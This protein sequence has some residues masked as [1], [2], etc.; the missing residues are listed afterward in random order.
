M[1]F[2][3]IE[4]QNNIEENY[5]L[6]LKQIK[7]LCIGNENNIAILSNASALLKIFL[8]DVNWVGFYLLDDISQD[9]LLGPFQGLPACFKIKKGQGVCGFAVKINSLVNVDDVKLF[10]NHIACDFN[11]KSEL[12]IPI[13]INNKI[14]GVL[15][16]DAPIKSRFSIIDEKYLQKFVNILSDFLK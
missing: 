16:I 3:N 10:P 15:D 11:T 4:Y 12:V 13:F 2:K 14:Y 1:V 7:E 8:K 9:L 6:L 5:Q